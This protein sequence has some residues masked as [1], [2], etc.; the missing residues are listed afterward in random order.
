MELV[1]FDSVYDAKKSEGLKES[2]HMIGILSPGAYEKALKAIPAALSLESGTHNLCS[3]RQIAVA[4]VH[5]H[6]RDYLGV[7]EMSERLSADRMEWFLGGNARLASKGYEFRE[8]SL[9]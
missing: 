3:P 7:K 4:Q 2:G 8:F 9:R 1:P 5:R 6:I